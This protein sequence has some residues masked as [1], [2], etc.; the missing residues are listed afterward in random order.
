MDR[1]PSQ[2]E[3]LKPSVLYHGTA[4]R[5]LKQL[6]PQN[7][8]IRDP[9]EGPV[10]FATTRKDLAVCFCLP[11]DDSWVKIG[12]GNN[13]CEIVIS[14]ERRFRQLDQGGI[15]YE[16]PSTTFTCDINKGM[17][18]LEWTSKEPVVVHGQ[19]KY[20]S[21]LDGLIQEGVTVYFVSQ[22]FFEQYVKNKEKRSEMLSGVISENQK[23]EQESRT[24][25]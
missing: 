7:K 20:K 18:E 17:K 8:S 1:E 11:T 10:V 6:V 5:N 2:L 21:V 22:D 15:V 16:L 23:R 4:I 3:I 12:V 14:D 24:R 13:K 25:S 9:E 19:T